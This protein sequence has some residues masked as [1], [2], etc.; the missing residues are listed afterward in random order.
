MGKR[1]ELKNL[2]KL[3]REKSRASREKSFF[4]LINSKLVRNEDKNE[5]CS[6]SVNR[7]KETFSLHKQSS[8]SGSS[9]RPTDIKSDGKAL[10]VEE[11]RTFEEIK[12]KEKH[13]EKLEESLRRNKN[14]GDRDILNQKLKKEK[15]ILS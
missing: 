9:K 1:E 2:S 4:D 15:H 3:E 13:I 11:M 6:S 14:S 5:K 10:K 7:S 12:R 8:K